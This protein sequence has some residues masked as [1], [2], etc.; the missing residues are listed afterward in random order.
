MCFWAGSVREVG[1]ALGKVRA[2]LLAGRISVGDAAA[3]LRCLA[4]QLAPDNFCVHLGPNPAS[5]LSERL[6][7]GPLGAGRTPSRLLGKSASMHRVRELIE[8]VAPTGLP[9][10]I[11]GESGTGKELIARAL[12]ETSKVRAGRF[13]AVNCAALSEAVLES[14][15][16]GHVRGAFTD[17]A[18]DR[19]GR[20]EIASP[21]TLF[22]DE[23]EAMTVTL[24]A[25]LLRVL[26]EHEVWPVGAERATPVDVRV[27]AATNQSL[28]ELVAEGRFRAD[29]YYRL[30]VFSILVPALRDRTED[31]LLLAEHFLA[32]ASHR[33]ERGA[34]WFTPGALDVLAHHTWP[35]NVRELRNVV[36]SALVLSLGPG[37]DEPELLDA[38]QRCSIMPATIP[39]VASGTSSPCDAIPLPT[40][41]EEIRPLLEIV[42]LYTRRCAVLTKGNVSELGRLLGGR[43]QTLAKQLRGWARQDGLRSE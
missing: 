23:I 6:L 30:N 26:E 15:L 27:V 7:A 12:H 35:G 10:L 39:S 18:R 13:V 36:E 28:G 8:R 37:L 40:R 11:R 14:E 19:K 20:F 2:D 24:Q 38:L 29:L 4:L 1:A 42:K 41:A 3:R 33:Q 16:F 9:V 25:K 31:I 22:L 21:G 43:R 32:E 34:T 5:P 17:A